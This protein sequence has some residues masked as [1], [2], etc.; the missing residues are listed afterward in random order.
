MLQIW[1]FAIKGGI[2]LFIGVDDHVFLGERFYEL[3]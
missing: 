3:I 1:V 2:G